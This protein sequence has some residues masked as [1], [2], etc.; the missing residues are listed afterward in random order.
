MTAATARLA[1]V[2]AAAVLTLI[3]RP[4]PAL[5]QDFPSKMIR[6]I[7]PYTPGSP[8]DVVARLLTQQLQGKLN[9]PV[10]I[11]NKPGGG[12]TIG[13]KAAAGAPADGYT[14]LF[15]SS[16]LVIE[17][18]LSKQMEYD[19]QKDFTPIAFVASN[20]CL[21]TIN[22]EVPANSVKEFVDY[23]KANP[24][25]L[26]LGFAQG[27]VS[28]LVGEY[29]NRL[30]GLDITSVPYRGGALVIPDMLG[31]RVHMYWADA[32]DCAA[33]DPGGQ[34]QGAGHFQPA[35]QLRSAAGSDHE[36]AGDRRAVAGI[37]G[38]GVGAGRNPG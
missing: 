15:S 26:S 16:A 4:D 24:G 6:I 31:G 14:L 37:L 21:L 8:N 29:F 12:T 2:A 20:S 33:A 27:T 17:P 5:A 35:A 22:A 30:H 36:R 32:R 10:V 25:K 18:A 19:P 13:S 23:A 11:D 34:D 3:G 7:V 1:V 38:R 9:Q 28:Q